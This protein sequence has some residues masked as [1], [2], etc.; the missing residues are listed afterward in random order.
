MSEE[1]STG[2]QVFSSLSLCPSPSLSLHSL[3]S[4]S[5]SLPQVADLN[6][7]RWRAPQVL[8]LELTTAV[9]R[10]AALPCAASGQDVVS[11][12]LSVVTPC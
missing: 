7:V 5:L 3:S 1:A 10:R 4:L 2:W 11:T 8:P 9:V 6:S 12:T